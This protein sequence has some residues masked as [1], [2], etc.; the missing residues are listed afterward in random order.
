[1]LYQKGTGK[2]EQGKKAALYNKQQVNLIHLD[3][4]G[5]RKPEYKPSHP[6][7]VEIIAG[8]Q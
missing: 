6:P 2:L 7:F 3:L 8:P 5:I 1:M 4:V